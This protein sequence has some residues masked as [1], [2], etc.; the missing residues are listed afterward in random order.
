ME[1]LALYMEYAKRNKLFQMD[2][3]QIRVTVPKS[4][5]VKLEFTLPKGTHLLK[6]YV[7]CDLAR[8]T[9][10]IWSR[11]RLPKARIQL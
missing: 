7:I 10:L 1:K 9:T 6:L 3:G 11:S 5:G 8:T 2:S 4:L